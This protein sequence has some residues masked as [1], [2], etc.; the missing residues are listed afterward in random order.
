VTDLS[1]LVVLDYETCDETGLGST[2]WYRPGFRAVCAAFTWRDAS[3]EKRSHWC[4]DPWLV[5]KEL[6]KKQIPVAA[7]NISFEMGVTEAC[8]PEVE[9]AWTLDSMRLAALYD[10]GDIGEDY[11]L[12][13][14]E[15]APKRDGL[16]LSACAQRILGKSDSKQAAEALIAKLYPEA[17]V[18]EYGR[19][20]PILPEADLRLYNIGDTDLTF[21]LI[22]QILKAFEVEGYDWQPDHSIYLRECQLI[23]DAQRRGIIVDREALA[24]YQAAIE[25][26]VTDIEQRFQARMGKDIET[27]RDVMWKEARAKYK[28]DKGKASCERPEFN[29]GSKTQLAKLFVDQVGIRPKFYTDKGAPSETSP[30]GT[31]SFRTN[32]I[33]QFGEGGEILQNRGRRLIV[34]NQAKKLLELS[35]EDGRWH[36]RINP[37]G[38]ATGRGAGEGGVNGQGLARRDYGLMSTLLAPPGKFLFSVDLSAGEPSLITHFSGD[39]LYRAA[40]FD[41]V[42]KKPYMENGILMIGDI[43]LM[44]GSVSPFAKE[45]L[46]AWK[47][48]VYEGRTFA[49]QWELDPEVITKSLKKF[50]SFVKMI[51]LALG[52]GLGPKRMI[53]HAQKFGFVITIEEARAFYRAYWDLFGGVREF[54]KKLEAEFKRKG[55]LYNAFGYRLVPAAGYK[56]LNYF[57][58]SGVSGLM[59]LINMELFTPDAPCEF[60][61]LIHDED[62]GQA[63]E[64]TQPIV[65]D[66]KNKVMENVNATLGWDVTIRTGWATGSNFYEAK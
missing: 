51:C 6:A 52:Y 24:S 50:R 47:Y 36:M 12:D 29:I 59:N 25:G 17:K 53:T 20:K 40:T 39:K 63:D 1:K 9:L 19:Y 2:D 62:L 16:S 26:E 42:G 46:D 4:R 45:L 49:E 44:V 22:E 10:A 66:F 33:H 23:N 7:H 35:A 3:G 13:D 57:I 5:L 30:K 27:V 8:Y 56:S 48:G 32:H 15:G 65:L 37:Q 11:V 61:G 43:Y 41:M 38:T 28:T 64:G 34:A 21:D 60:V 14:E 18:S 58:Q 31:P 54:G 55:Y